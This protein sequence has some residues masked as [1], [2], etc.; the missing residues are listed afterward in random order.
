MEPDTILMQNIFLSIVK[1]RN[2]YIRAIYLGTARGEMH[3]WGIGEGLVNNE[4]VFPPDYDPRE[5][6]WYKTAV[7]AGDYT[8]SEPYIYASIQALGIT[9]V[10]P[11]YNFSGEFTGVLGIDIIFESLSNII[12]DLKFQEQGKIILLNHKNQILVDQVNRIEGNRKELLFFPYADSIREDEGSLIKNIYGKKTFL[13]YKKSNVTGWKVLVATDY[14]DLMALSYQNVRIIL[15]AN[16]LFMVI[17]II[18]II[19][20]TWRMITSPLESIIST[21][22]ERKGGDIKA[23]IN[24]ERRDEFGM[25]AELFNGLSDKAEESA[26]ILE[27]KVRERTEDLIKLQQENSLLRILEEKERIFADLHDSLG[28]RLTNIN[29]SNQVAQKAYPADAS[30]L[31]DMLNHIEKNVKSGIEDL[32]R[33]IFDFQSPRKVSI[34]FVHF[35]RVNIEDRLKLKGITLSFKTKSSDEINKLNRDLRLHLEKLLQELTTNVLKHADARRVT[36]TMDIKE[37]NLRFSFEDN[38]IGFDRSAPQETGFGLSNI[39]GR[40]E[41]MGGTMKLHSKAGKGTWYHFTLPT[42]EAESS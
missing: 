1:W 2:E 17:L 29:I 10:I 22:E 42:G 34:N 6:P 4:P 12:S 13:S 24:L 38:G 14:K 35:M 9:A 28:A 39:S 32:Q 30:V 31:Q 37:K 8:I 7:K 16:I 23:R 27:D 15:L 26:K 25:M 5:R 3:E 40:V 20:I 41:K 19:S 36:I 33:I 18:L 21:L 11:V